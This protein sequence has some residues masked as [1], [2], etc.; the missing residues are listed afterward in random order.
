MKRQMLTA[1]LSLLAG[2]TL[3]ACADAQQGAMLDR[4]D[5]NRD[6]RISRSE[7]QAAR[8]DMFDRL[9]RN[10]DG[11]IDWQDEFRRSRARE[12]QER[13]VRVADRDG[14]GA[15][16]RPEYAATPMV[17]FDRADTNGDDWLD[18]REIEAL[19]AQAAERR[20]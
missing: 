18:A 14:D 16:S 7:Y 11:W 4:A 13:L 10:G 6:G 17:L 12:A 9:D 2:A 5:A 3:T 8:L 1:A 20:G 19:R 15:V